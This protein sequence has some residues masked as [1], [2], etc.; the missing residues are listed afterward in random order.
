MYEKQKKN[1]L[2]VDD[3]LNIIQGLKR[4]FY[5]M[6][7][8]WEMFFAL[9]GD[10]ALNILEENPIDVVISD[11]RMPNM[12]GAELLNKVCV[13]YPQTVRIILSGHSD[14]KMILKS[15]KSTHQF[16]AKPCNPDIL[17]G[18]IE[19]AVA[20]RDVLMDKNLI[21]IVTGAGNLPSLPDLYY[22]LV[23][24]LNSEDASL[25]EIGN[26]IKSDIVMTAKILQLVNSAFFGLPQTVM[27][28][29]Q[30]VNLLGT[31]TI[32]A[33]ILSIGIFSAFSKVRT[34]GF[35]LENLWEHSMHVGTLAKK[36]MLDVTS[37]T[38]KAE[39]TVI[40]GLLHDIG[41]LLMIQTEGYSKKISDILMEKEMTIS[42]AEYKVFGTSHAEVGAY[43]LS[44]WG[45]PSV[46]IESVA[47]H[48]NPS[49]SLSSNFSILT[50]LHVSNAFYSHRELPKNFADSPYLDKKYLHLLKIES[51]LNK[52]EKFYTEILKMDST[53]EI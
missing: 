28:P 37:D 53:N 9:S 1:I 50:A 34:P 32:K 31:E 30:A 27:N 41:K 2:F 11:M 16:I 49:N 43:L 51:K 36:I 19:R 20:L 18:T 52:W 26:I 5:N 35:S 14:E 45:L 4:M 47:Y 12:D 13:L 39:D 44:L 3:E 21:R 38:Q 10:E 17:K 29:Q 42:E 46:I 25:K 8:D 33:L 48:H 15:A 22:R 23:E 7:N 40:A 6:K 24:E